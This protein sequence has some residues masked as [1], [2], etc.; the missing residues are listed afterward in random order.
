MTDIQR[1][2][3]DWSGINWFGLLA[4][5]G[6]L[7]SLLQ[8]NSSKASVLWCSAF[9]MV[10]GMLFNILKHAGNPPTKTNPTQV[11]ALLEL[12]DVLWCS[13]SSGLLDHPLALF[14]FPLAGTLDFSIC[15]SS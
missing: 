7:K 9:F 15:L 3:I 8:H 5:Q 6:T 14:L 2:P 1:M 13:H 12:R 4:V 10:Q 11:L